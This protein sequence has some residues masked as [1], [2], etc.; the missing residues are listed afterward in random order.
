[1]L[2]CFSV[3]GFCSELLAKERKDFFWQFLELQIAAAHPHQGAA[4][5]G[6]EQVFTA[7]DQECVQQIVEQG[8]SLLGPSLSPLFRLSLS[9]R[10]ASPKVL[11]YQQLAQESLAA[12][13]PHNNFL[14]HTTTTTPNSESVLNKEET[15]P[16]HFT[17][18]PYVADRWSISKSPVAPN[19][20][21]SSF[22][23]WVDT[24]SGILLQESELLDWLK[25][26]KKR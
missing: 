2:C 16:Q 22:C 4:I 1:V 8:S 13:A 24:S 25:L 3:V 6:Q 15:D 10:S 17:P 26:I 14:S 19:G 7:T 18:K 23:C 11:L 21:T 20:G 5:G 12:A 9:L